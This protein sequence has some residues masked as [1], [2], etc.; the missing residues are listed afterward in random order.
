[1]S[2]L[3]L[4][5]ACRQSRTKVLVVFSSLENVPH[6]RVLGLLYKLE[7][8]GHECLEVYS[9]KVKNV[10]EQEGGFFEAK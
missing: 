7:G 3:A 5:N 4:R 8:S 9:E 6:N 1:M 2:K 10:I